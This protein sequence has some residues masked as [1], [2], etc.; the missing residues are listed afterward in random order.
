VSSPDS[1]ANP[2]PNDGQPNSHIVLLG[3][4]FPVLHQGAPIMPSAT[5]SADV[6][7]VAWGDVLALQSTFGDTTFTVARITVSGDAD[8]SV[9]GRVGGIANPN[10]PSVVTYYNPAALRIVAVPEPAALGL[11]GI[12]AAMPLI[13]CRRRN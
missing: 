10:N 4:A 9:G 5:N 6:M 12:G 7:D 2:T 3:R 8:A 1:L 13:R 11:L